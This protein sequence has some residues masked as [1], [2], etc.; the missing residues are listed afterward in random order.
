MNQNGFTLI[1]L[2]VTIGL[3]SV[4]AGIAFFSSQGMMDGYQVKG[5]ARLVYS[6][7]QMARLK[8]IRE[9]KEWSVCVDP[10]GTFTSY[11]VRNSGGATVKTIDIASMYSGMTFSENLGT[12]CF[13]FK[14]N[15]TATSGT[16]TVTKG[17]RNVEVTVSSGTGNIRIE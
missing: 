16:V 10:D 5:A 12:A 1:E 15:G 13:E 14:E 11:V 3:I 9:G 7:M 4:L 8:A 17:A 6:D 2:L